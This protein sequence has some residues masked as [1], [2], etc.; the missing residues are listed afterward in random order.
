LRLAIKD[1]AE[2]RYD[3]RHNKVYQYFRPRFVDDE[4]GQIND[5]DE[6]KMDTNWKYLISSL[7]IILSPKKAKLLAILIGEPNTGKT[8]FLKVIKKPIEPIVS[9]V[10]LADIQRDKFGKEPLLGKQV[11]ITSETRDVFITK[12]GVLNELFGEG[13]TISV[14]RKNQ[15][16]V[17]MESLKMGIISTNDPPII[18]DKV[19]GAINAFINR[20]NLIT[21]T[22]PANSENISGLADMI[23]PEEAFNFLLWCRVWL[24][25]H[26]W[27][28]MK[29]TPEEILNVLRENSNT[30]Y[31]FLDLATELIDFDVNCKMKVKRLY[32]LYK[33]WCEKH[34]I[35]PMGRNLFYDK[36]RDKGYELYDRKGVKWV[37]GICEKGKPRDQT[38]DDMEP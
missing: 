19:S 30:A 4:N 22:R 8:T 10:S 2:G 13:D 25:K 27:Q 3:I 16:Y 12:V 14:N 11:L 35:K 24:E 37:R 32:E 29:P 21:M 5:D 15:K 17:E 36:L 20:L 9:S 26:N 31:Q 33:M 38:L 6:E 28:I 34:G 18:Q 23:S 7:G 1:I